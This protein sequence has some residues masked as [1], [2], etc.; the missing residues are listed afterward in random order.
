MRSFRWECVSRVRRSGSDDKG[1][2][3]LLRYTVVSSAQDSGT[4][5]ETEIFSSPLDVVE[6]C[7]AQELPYVLHD[8]NLGPYTVHNFHIRPPKLLSRIGRSLLVQ[9]AEALARWATDYNIRVW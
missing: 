9:Q 3:P 8:K 5:I 4:D 2:V 1:A 6:F 7:R